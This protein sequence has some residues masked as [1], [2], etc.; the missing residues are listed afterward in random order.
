MPEEELEAQL[1]GPIKATLEGT[2]APDG[3][4]V[5]VI[6]GQV[7]NAGV[8]QKLDGTISTM[9]TS[10]FVKM[11]DVPRR[12]QGEV[13]GVLN[14]D[15]SVQLELTSTVLEDM[16]PDM[17]VNQGRTVLTQP[18]PKLINTKSGVKYAD[19]EAVEAVSTNTVNSAKQQLLSGD[20]N[21]TV[22]T[23]KPAG[24]SF[25]TAPPPRKTTMNPLIQEFSFQY[26]NPGLEPL[27]ERVST[28]TLDASRGL[29][30]Y[31]S[32]RDPVS[33]STY[34]R[35]GSKEAMAQNSENYWE[36][37]HTDPFVRLTEEDGSA[38]SL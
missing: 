5:G 4:I 30:I 11:S 9:F 33:W 14:A 23:S 13:E 3:K 19:E 7:S 2:L 6:K 37:P 22:K 38:Y 21:L 18:I 16:R 10:S 34:T 29:A 27:I 32:V 17:S 24:L 28:K 15:G 12:I 8:V 20:P 25:F 36:F 26:G 35:F 1:T 31:E